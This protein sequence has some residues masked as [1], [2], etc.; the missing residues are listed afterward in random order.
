MKIT[1]ELLLERLKYLENKQYASNTMENYFTDVK[2]FLEF[3]KSDLLV[4]TVDVKDLTL[5]EIEKWKNE[6]K[7]E[8]TKKFPLDE[9][10]TEAKAKMPPEEPKQNPVKISGTQPVVVKNRG[11]RY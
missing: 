9:Q 10:I 1:N 5:L 3:T 7:L 11:E 4:S 8:E 6:Q 2:L